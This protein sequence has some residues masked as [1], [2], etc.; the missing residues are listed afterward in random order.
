MIQKLNL[1]GFSGGADLRG[2]VVAL[3]S[4]D[5]MHAG[6]RAVIDRAVSSARG[7]GIA[8]VVFTFAVPP[9]LSTGANASGL[10]TTL[11]EKLELLAEAGVDFAAVADFSDLSGMTAERFIS[12]A[13]RGDL[14]AEKVVCGYD[15]SFGSGRA[16]NA[17]TLRAAFGPD[18]EFVPAVCTD[19]IPVSSSRIRSLLSAGKAGQAASLLG[20][21]YSFEGKVFR[22]RGDGRRLGFPTVN[23]LP[24]E[25]KQRLEPGVYVS[26]ISVGGSF[27]PAVSDV[28]FA[29]TVDKTGVYRCET[30]IL[31][32][33]GRFDAASARVRFLEFLRPERVFDSESELISAVREDVRRAEAYFSGKL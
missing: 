10:L 2:S 17:E 26:E 7:A 24:P 21:P 11:D 3:G 25:Q 19:G 6:H 18:A 13:L 1:S 31:S 4:F 15:F 22:G 32:F 23:L 29:P 12:E 33:D 30:H 8:S 5:G 16:G 28:G 20:R 14:R 27:L 9:S